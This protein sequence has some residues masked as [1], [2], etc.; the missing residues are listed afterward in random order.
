MAYVIHD[1]LPWVALAGPLATDQDELASRDRHRG[2]DGVPDLFREQ[3]PV[4]ARFARQ[5]GR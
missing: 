1:P 2:K 3:D 4:A 5:G